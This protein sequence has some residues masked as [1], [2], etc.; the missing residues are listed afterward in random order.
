MQ[1]LKIVGKLTFIFK[2]SAEICTERLCL[3][4]YRENICT[5]QY[6]NISIPAVLFKYS[7]LF[8]FKNVGGQCIADPFM[9]VR[10]AQVHS[11]V[12]TVLIGRM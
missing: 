1:S 6:L 5:L 4:Y 7:A 3:Y 12:L 8:E 2:S 11:H 10:R 9:P